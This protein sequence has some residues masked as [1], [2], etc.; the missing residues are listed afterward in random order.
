MSFLL[1]LLPALIAGLSGGASKFLQKDPKMEKLDVLNPGQQN[2]QNMILSLFGGQGGQ[3]GGPLGS[4]QKMLSDDPEAFKEFEA[5]FK[6]Q[7]EEQTVPGLAERFSGAGA[8]A[9]RSSAFGQALSSAGAGLSENLA[10]LRGGLKMNALS[11]LMNLLPA[12]MQPSFAYQEKQQRSPWSDIFGGF[13]S[14]VAGGAGQL[15]P[16][17]AKKYWGIG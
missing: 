10:Q 4:L 13:G 2:F 9:Q 15:T 12:A 7:F 14:G 8:G 6:R 16:G 5:P 17:L 3:M 11:Q 1:P